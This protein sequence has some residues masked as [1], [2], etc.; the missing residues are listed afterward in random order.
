MIFLSSGNVR[1]ATFVIQVMFKKFPPV[2]TEMNHYAG[3][4]S[5]VIL[6]SGKLETTSLTPNC[7][8]QPSESDFLWETNDKIM[9]EDVFTGYAQTTFQSEKSLSL[10]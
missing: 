3:S 9:M 4:G 8:V 7:S 10:F 2:A 5:R 6:C 1:G